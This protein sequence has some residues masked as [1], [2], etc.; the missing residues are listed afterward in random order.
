MCECMSTYI[1]IYIY[2]HTSYL[3]TTNHNRPQ[4]HDQG[5]LAPDL[6]THLICRY[7]RIRVAALHE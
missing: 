3:P 4:V 2:T 5:P 6:G 1:Y 7:S